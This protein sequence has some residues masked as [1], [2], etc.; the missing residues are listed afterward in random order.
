MRAE[1]DFQ[2]VRQMLKGDQK[3]FE[4][5]FESYF[6][7]L[8]RFVLV[9]VARDESAAEEIVQ[10]ALCKAIPKL[11]TYRGEAMLFTWLCTFCRHEIAHYQKDIRKVSTASLIEDSPEILAAMESLLGI[12]EERPDEVLLR[13]EVSHFV[14]TILAALP[15]HYADVLEWKYIEGISVKEVAERLHLGVKAAESLLT[16]AREAFKDA[17]TSSYKPVVLGT[18]R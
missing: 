15:S 6:P 3:A 7:G 1:T 11:N 8:Y 2:V 10:A 4:D 9:R 16:R 17:F 12:V 5:F 18:E 14:Q 13:N